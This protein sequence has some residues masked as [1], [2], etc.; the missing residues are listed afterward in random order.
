MPGGS[1]KQFTLLP[2]DYTGIDFENSV[3]ETAERSLNF[4]EYFYAGSGVAVGDVNNDGLPDVFFTGNDVPNRL[5]INKGDFKFEDIS[6]KAGIQSANWGQG[7]SMVDINKDGWLDIYVCN[8]GPAANPNAMR[9]E[10]YVNNGNNTFTE[11]AA[12]YG[13]DDNSRS[14]QATFFDMDQDGDL[15]LVIKVL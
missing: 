14:M 13:I 5:Y 6:K 9:N 8:S 15:D 12:K 3:Q 11:Q 4:Y 2:A 7:V 1:G 10:L